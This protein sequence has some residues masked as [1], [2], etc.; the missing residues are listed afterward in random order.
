MLKLYRRHNLSCRYKNFPSF[1]N[2]LCPIWYKGDV[3]GREVNQ[4]AKT[5]DLDNA[6]RLRDTL[7][8]APVSLV[9]KQ[10]GDFNNL[11]K[12]IRDYL[13]GIRGD[14]SKESL[15]S[16]ENTLSIFEEWVIE[17]SGQIYVKQVD[18]FL[19]EK[20]LKW[21]TNK[22]G[23]TTKK[24]EVIHLRTFFKWCLDRDLVDRNPAMKVKL[25]K[26]QGSLTLPFTKDEIDAMRKFCYSDYYNAVFYTLL[27]TGL[28]VSDIVGLRKDSIKD[29]KIL[30]RMEK[31]GNPVYLKLN[32]IALQAILIHSSYDHQSN[33]VF[34]VSTNEI[35][36][37]I[38]IIGERSKVENAHPHR[39]RDTFA[40]NLLLNGVDIRTVQLLLG[41]TSLTT[42]EKHYAPF[43]K[44]FQQKL[45]DA[46]GKLS[47]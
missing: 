14:I 28:R 4:S 35:R 31:T 13:L 17:T 37:A 22:I 15:R 20:Y 39:F 42:T 41:H 25:A 27:Y 26:T 23:Q 11:S 19:I 29:G 32:P 10:R 9:V 45:D 30:L 33:L 7:E 8:K 47:F 1:D 12:V 38:K 34:P 44:E 43:V 18:V 6:V 3:D 5:R 16:Y 40:V 24:K 21:R 46:V 36:E 2:C